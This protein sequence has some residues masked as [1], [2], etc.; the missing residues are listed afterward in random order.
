MVETA[1]T[2]LIYAAVIAAAAIV[3]VP[4]SKFVWKC[5]IRK[6]IREERRQQAEADMREQ[7][8]LY[9]EI[10]LKQALECRGCEK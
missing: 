2:I 10:M 3:A 1:M 8:K 4:V 5:F 7:A 6:R 9:Q